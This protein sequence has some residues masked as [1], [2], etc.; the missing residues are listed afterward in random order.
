MSLSIGHQ[1]D[2]IAERE[3]LTGRRNGMSVSVFPQLHISESPRLFGSQW[4]GNSRSTSSVPCC[5]EC[6]HIDV[7]VLEVASP[8]VLL[9]AAL[10][11]SQLC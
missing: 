11:F 3:D 9:E 2:Y 10:E 8:L 1:G 6:L 4:T 7:L 5:V